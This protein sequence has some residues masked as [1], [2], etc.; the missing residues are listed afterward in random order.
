LITS[1]IIEALDRFEE[2]KE[3]IGRVRESGEE[4]LPSHEEKRN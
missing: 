2:F 1:R 4:G 3:I